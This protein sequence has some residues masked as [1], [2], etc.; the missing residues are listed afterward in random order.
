[1]LLEKK[2]AFKIFGVTAPGTVT[3]T[4]TVSTQIFI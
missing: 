4:A 1:M 2:C 3:P